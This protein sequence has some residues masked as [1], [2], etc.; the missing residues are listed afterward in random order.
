[1]HSDARTSEGQDV[2]NGFKMAMRRLASTVTVITTAL[3]GRRYG[4]AA[5][6]VTSV[7]AH[8]PAL[9]VCINQSAS[10]HG[11]TI[12][13]GRFCINLL[14]VDHDDMVGPFSGQAAGED[15]FAYGTWDAHSGGLPYLLDAQANLFCVLTK[16]V[17]YGSHSIFVG[18]VEQVRLCGD[19]EP[20]I[21][22][23]GGLYRTLGLPTQ[24]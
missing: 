18:E 12:A 4:M 16:R 2:L 9:L 22:Q 6:S 23:D 3:D 8:P 11:P 17:S 13:N 7:T 10:I 14:G 15:R 5:T 24:S 21:Y 20:L 19:T 1:M